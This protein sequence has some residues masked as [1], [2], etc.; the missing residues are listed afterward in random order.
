MLC[1]VVTAIP[2]FAAGK[3]SYRRKGNITDKV[4]GEEIVQL[5][6]QMHT[7]FPSPPL[8][9]NIKIYDKTKNILT[10]AVVAPLPRNLLY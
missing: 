5:F 4:C 1:T 3:A 7:E 9:C 10:I 8:Y 6:K 2:V